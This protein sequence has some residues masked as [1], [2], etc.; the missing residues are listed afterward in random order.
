MDLAEWIID[1][2]CLV[3]T[4]SSS[5]LAEVKLAKVRE[6]YL[7][8]EKTLSLLWQKLFCACPNNLF[9]SFIN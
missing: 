2:T 6:F 9:I 8:E 5:F 3:Y 4:L 1:D 7:K